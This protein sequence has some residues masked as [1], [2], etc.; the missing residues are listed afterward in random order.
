MTMKPIDS[1]CGDV[2]TIPEFVKAVEDGC[3]IDYDG[4]GEYATAT[5]VS[6]IMVHPSDILAG[7]KPPAEYTHVVWYNR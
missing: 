3:F 1:D 6:D 4:F 5:E 2:M 7:E